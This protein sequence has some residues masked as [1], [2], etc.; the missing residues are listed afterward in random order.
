MLLGLPRAYWF[1]F[2]GTLVNRLGS[3]VF[4]YLAL[5]L[6]QARGFTDEAAGAVVGLYG[7]GA[8]AAGPVAGVI[9][10]RTGRRLVML[11]S[12]AGGAAAMLAL[13]AAERPEAIA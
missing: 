4:T 13:S 7:L 9:A 11:L 2:A 6:T 3:F 10:D 1:L 5:Y 12:T 8:L